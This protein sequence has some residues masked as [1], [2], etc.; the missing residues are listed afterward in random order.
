[1]LLTVYYYNDD[2]MKQ[3][4]AYFEF[5]PE[6]LQE[7][8]KKL[9]AVRDVCQKLVVLDNHPIYLF[10]FRLFARLFHHKQDTISFYIS[11]TN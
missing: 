8:V 2:E 5:T 10:Y 11:P 9:H 3:H 7:F 1:M 6:Q 4:E